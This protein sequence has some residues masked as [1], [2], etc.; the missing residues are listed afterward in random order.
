LEKSSAL[1]A[2][3]IATSDSDSLEEEHAALWRP[4]NREQLRFAD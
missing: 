1:L 3:L 2:S 4:N